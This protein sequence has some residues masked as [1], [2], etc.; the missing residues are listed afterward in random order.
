MILSTMRYKGYKW[1]HNPASLIIATKEEIK[2]QMIL[3]SKSFVRDLGAKAKVVKGTS[4]LVGKDCIAQYGQL[5]K[6]QSKGGSGILSLPDTLPF[7]AFFKSIELACDPTPEVVT[8]NFEFVEDL[9]V[10]PSKGDYAYH[11]VDEKE[12]LW[13]IS[14]KYDIAIEKLVEFNPQVSRVDELTVGEQVRIC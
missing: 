13:D 1:Q 14:Y 6:L 4:Q 8:Y 3:Q 10:E 7:Y 12:S 11:T 9:S 2:E 5:L